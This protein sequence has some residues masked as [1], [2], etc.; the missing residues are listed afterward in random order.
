MRCHYGA[1]PRAQELASAPRGMVS[2]AY[3]TQYKAGR[4]LTPVR[5][6]SSFSFSESHWVPKSDGSGSCLAVW[7]VHGNRIHY[8][9]LARN[10]RKGSVEY[11]ECR[12]GAKQ[13][14]KYEYIKL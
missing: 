3:L 2:A 14:F 4:E 9:S 12:K 6:S 8:G 11:Q 1:V 7:D 10:H 13:W 5:T